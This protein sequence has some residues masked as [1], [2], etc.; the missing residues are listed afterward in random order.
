MKIKKKQQLE[1]KY[2]KEQC[3]FV[4]PYI[5][6]QSWNLCNIYLKLMIK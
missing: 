5:I 6:F 3:I 4:I 2:L 1:P